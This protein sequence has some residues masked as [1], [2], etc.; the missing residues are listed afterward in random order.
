M[1]GEG[2][3]CWVEVYDENVKMK[4]DLDK[5]EEVAEGNQS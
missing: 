5:L 1:I 3:N 2:L 4:V